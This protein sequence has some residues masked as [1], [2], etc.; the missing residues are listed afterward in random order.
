MDPAI[1]THAFPP[2]IPAAQY[3]A[4]N[5]CE[6]FTNVLHLHYGSSHD[7]QHQRFLLT[8]NLHSFLDAPG[9]LGIASIGG[10]P[11]AW[12]AAGAVGHRCILR[13]GTT[14]IF[15][16]P[17]EASGGASAAE[18]QGGMHWRVRDFY[19]PSYAA[20]LEAPSPGESSD[21]SSSASSSSASSRSSSDSASGG[22]PPSRGSFASTASRFVGWLQPIPVHPTC[23]PYLT[24]RALRLKAVAMRECL[25]PIAAERAAHPLAAAPSPGSS[26]GFFGCL[27]AAPASSDEAASARAANTHA[28]RALRLGQPLPEVLL[29]EALQ[30]MAWR[31]AF[32]LT[33]APSHPSHH[34]GAAARGARAG[35]A[36]G[37]AVVQAPVLLPPNP[38][39]LAYMHPPALCSP[40]VRE[41]PGHQ[42]LLSVTSTPPPQ[43]L[44]LCAALR[45]APWTAA[46]RSALTVEALLTVDVFSSSSAR[47][48]EQFKH[49]CEGVQEAAHGAEC[50][51]AAQARAYGASTLEH[52]LQR[53]VSGAAPRRRGGRAAP[54][55][56]AQRLRLSSHA[57]RL[58]PHATRH[59]PPSPPPE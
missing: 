28:L 44:P 50:G 58:T 55:G 7:L 39:A 23:L 31:A 29:P 18:R 9:P 12:V 1:G 6:L 4:A 3:A 5:P 46:L 38:Y 45:A 56:S 37:A 11:S 32:A 25:G 19:S 43:L 51:M 42:Q 53:A 57:R 36:G 13:D 16:V 47:S 20:V 30:P 14:V 22:A 41:L 27:A 10:L 54:S 34:C 15:L 26:L 8:P 24:L 48:E 59:T 17:L 33:P 35:L 21:G 40:L 52:L 49:A 2:C